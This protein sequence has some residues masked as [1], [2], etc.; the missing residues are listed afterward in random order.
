MVIGKGDEGFVPRAVVPGQAAGLEGSVRDDGVQDAFH[1]LH[2]NSAAVPVIAV[3]SVIAIHHF[4]EKTGRRQLFRVT[5]NHRRT[6]FVGT[7][8]NRA[9]GV[10]GQDLR[11]F[12]HD[13][14]VE[15]EMPGLQVLR[16]R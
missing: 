5:D 2:G 7:A 16:D 12:I 3:V 4:L 11:G 10:F 9:D 1:L 8:G 13:D 6:I 14:N 15:L